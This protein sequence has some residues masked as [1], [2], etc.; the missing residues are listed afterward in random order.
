MGEE[1][2]SHVSFGK[3]T[4]GVHNSIVS[5]N[6]T[7][8]MDSDRTLRCIQFDLPTAIAQSLNAF[9]LS[10]N[11]RFGQSASW[12][13][14]GFS[15]VP[16]SEVKLAAPSK[17]GGRGRPAFMDSFSWS[18]SAAPDAQT[19]TLLLQPQQSPCYIALLVSP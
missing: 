14:H 15:H 5:I 18:R 16:I 19:V 17:F 7:S 2:A 9:T 6:L 13:L 4:P 8:E 3:I 1:V 10:Q 11:P 12:N